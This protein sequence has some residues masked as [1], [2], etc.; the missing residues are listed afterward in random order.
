MT[1]RLELTRLIVSEVMVQSLAVIVSKVARDAPFSA[2]YTTQ[3]SAAHPNP[4]PNPYF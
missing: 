1:F 4:N 3:V 2:I